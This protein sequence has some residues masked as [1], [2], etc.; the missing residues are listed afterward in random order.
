MLLARMVQIFLLSCGP[1]TGMY[2]RA[3][4]SFEPIPSVSRFYWK[5][6]RRSRFDNESSYSWLITHRTSN[7]TTGNWDPK[8]YT[9]MRCASKIKPSYQHCPKYSILTQLRSGPLSTALHQIDFYTSVVTEC[10]TLSFERF[11]PVFVW[12]TSSCPSNFT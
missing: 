1:G 4:H 7:I 11:S 5:Q 9:N 3:S 10:L 2:K 8:I 6:K 12:G